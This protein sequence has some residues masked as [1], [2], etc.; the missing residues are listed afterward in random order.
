[1][2]KDK[3][4]IKK[5]LVSPYLIYRNS[6]FISSDTSRTMESHHE[7]KILALKERKI[8]NESL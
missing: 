2:L 8:Y 7:N 3:A 6:L 4:K 1:M 5:A